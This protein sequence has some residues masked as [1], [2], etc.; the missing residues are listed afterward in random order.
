VNLHPEHHSKADIH[1]A[2]TNRVSR[3]PILWYGSRRPPSYGD[4]L[5]VSQDMDWPYAWKCR[6]PVGE[7]EVCSEA[8][9]LY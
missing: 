2:S 8:A 9:I 7:A 3:H 6:Y 5:Q 4:R 1:N